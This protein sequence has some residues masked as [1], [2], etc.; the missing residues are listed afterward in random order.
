MIQ[1]KKINKIYK[2]G[3]VSY[4]ALHDIDLTIE[5]GEYVA[6]MG[7]S[8]SGK[9]TLMHLLGF[10]DRPTSG[11]YTIFG[12]EMTILDD[13]DLA[14]LRNHVAGFVFQQ[15]HLLSRT[16]AFDNVQIPLISS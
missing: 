16:S 13:D 15:F 1:L 10:L 2:T 9:S 8:G 11:S 14:R 4:Q 3:D 12:K 5:Q 6:I 7:Q